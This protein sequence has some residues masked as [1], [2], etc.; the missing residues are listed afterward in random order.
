MSYIYKD[1]ELLF[2]QGQIITLGCS[3]ILLLAH[4][5]RH[6]RFNEMVQSV[7]NCARMFKLELHVSILQAQTR[8]I[9]RDMAASHFMQDESLGI[10][11]RY[12]CIAKLLFK[13]ADV[14][15]LVRQKGKRKS[16]DHKLDV[17]HFDD[18][19]LLP[20]SCEDATLLVIPANSRLRHPYISSSFSAQPFHKFNNQLLCWYY[21][22]H[23]PMKLKKVADGG[24]PVSFDV[25]LNIS[26]SQHLTQNDS[27]WY[28]LKPQCLSAAH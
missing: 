24:E 20:P 16:G 3:K 14:H 27:K 10:Y 21:Q 5:C 17:T 19:T 1:A 15:N 22:L 8:Y 11:P 18:F 4:F 23:S 13:N 25:F 7:L 26:T 9:V 28:I 12:I 6:S 2:F